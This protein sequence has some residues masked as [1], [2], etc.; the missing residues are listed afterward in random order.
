MLAR[1]RDA[2]KVTGI[3]VENASISEIRALL[4]YTFNK[5]KTKSHQPIQRVLDEETFR[6]NERDENKCDEEEINTRWEWIK[7]CV[8]KETDM[9]LSIDE[10]ESQQAQLI[11][12][13]WSLILKEKLLWHFRKTKD[14]DA[15]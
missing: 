14:D 7:S 6:M 12:N 2:S 1:W 4:T 3:P 5:K 10:V 9:A 13:G 15:A 8:L 11:E